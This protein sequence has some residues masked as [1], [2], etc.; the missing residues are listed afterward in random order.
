MCQVL[1][2][3]PQIVIASPAQAFAGWLLVALLVVV[4][5]KW[6]PASSFRC[7]RRIADSNFV[8]H[9]DAFAQVQAGRNS[10]YA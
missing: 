8:S 10:S 3:P 6:P 5:T 4:H 1:T 7:R 2:G 9:T